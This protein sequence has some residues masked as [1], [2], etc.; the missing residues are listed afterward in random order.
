MRVSHYIDQ[1]IIS[2]SASRRTSSV[3]L[4]INNKIMN[5]L[6]ESSER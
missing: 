4:K 3:S 6:S 2:V 1:T 5:I